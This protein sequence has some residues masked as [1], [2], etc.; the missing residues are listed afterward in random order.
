MPTG[1]IHQEDRTAGGGNDVRGDV[2]GHGGADGIGGC[3]LSSISLLTF[4]SFQDLTLAGC[5]LRRPSTL[6][7]P[8]WLV[9]GISSAWLLTKPGR[10]C[11]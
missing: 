9:P 4:V 1:V 11:T 5:L 2:G 8:E 7:D 6:S 10:A 3:L